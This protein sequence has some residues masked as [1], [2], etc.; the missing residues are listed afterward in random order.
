MLRLTLEVGQ[1]FGLLYQFLSNDRLG[2]R[3]EL[4]D[5]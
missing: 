2:L 3:V 5:G 4:A 1:P